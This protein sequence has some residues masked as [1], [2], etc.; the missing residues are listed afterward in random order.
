MVVVGTT[1]G[2]RREPPGETFFDGDTKRHLTVLMLRNNNNKN[3]R[4]SGIIV[5]SSSDDTTLD[6]FWRLERDSED[7][8]TPMD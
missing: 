2:L 6:I 5:A 3:L 1:R 7:Q 4:P 8:K